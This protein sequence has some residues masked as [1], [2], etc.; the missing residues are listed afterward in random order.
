MRLLL[1]IPI[2]TF[3]AGIALPGWSQTTDELR[4]QL[5]AQKAINEALRRRVEE[6]ERQLAPGAQRQAPALRPVER[7]P[8][9]D[10]IETPESTSAIR[11]AL[12]ARGLLLLP[13][14]AFR[15][16]PRLTWSH[17]GSDALG[18]RSDTYAT[19]LTL[20]AGLPWDMMASASLP[21]VYRDSAVGSNRGVGD[22]S[23]ALSKTL[24]DEAD[25]WP[26]LVASI[27]YTHNS[28]KD[29]FERVP[30]G[31]GFKAVNA[32]LSAV[33]RV[34]PVALYGDVS[35]SHTYGR[36]V[37][38][39]NLLG[40]SR[41]VGRITPGQ[42]YGLSFGASLAATPGITLEGGFST[43]F[44]RSAE[45]ES[46]AFGTYR[47]PRATISFVTAGSGF[48]LTNRLALLITAG[49]GATKDS[50]DLLFSAT[51]PYR[52]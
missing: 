42:A 28:G 49:I 46:A 20:Q 5:E 39:S 8:L 27:G 44:I 14:G 13:A 45:V 32:R 30:I 40:E 23:V 37:T 11:E 16:A 36:N 19:S 3:C 35:Y 24:A 22:F 43:T 7:Q 17:T 52:F 34:D 12:V 25:R 10:D 9:P 41:F 50:P 4:Q 29:P 26:S 15:L 51:L 21:Y 1:A 6:L 18:T 2:A 33:K 31:S 47:L 48:V 38:A